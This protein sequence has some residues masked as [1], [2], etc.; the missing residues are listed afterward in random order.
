[1]SQLIPYMSPLRF[2]TYEDSINYLE[3]PPNIDKMMP[4]IEYQRGVYPGTYYPGFNIN[5]TISIEIH[6]DQEILSAELLNLDTSVSQPMTITDITPAV[7]DGEK[8]QLIEIAASEG[9]YKINVD[10]FSTGNIFS[11]EFLVKDWSKT[12]DL[13]EVE[14][15]DTLNRN[16]GYF[17]DETT[18]KWSP[19]V[20]Y[21]GN[22]LRAGTEFEKSEYSDQPN[23]TINLRITP[24]L[25]S[26]LTI[27][28]IHE[29]YY[30]NICHQFSCDTI[31]AN[32]T[33]YAVEEIGEP[34]P[35]EENTE[36]VNIIITLSRNTNNGFQ[37]FT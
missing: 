20:Y 16:G 30:D 31:I 8:I 15:R 7:W 37:Q 2:Y 3:F 25:K 36:L 9:Y 24:K 32:G 23:N 22:I 17:Y 29:S 33:Q 18:L 1:M 4:N 10:L 27:S 14:F 19:K 13:V 35:L 34:V 26:T 21:T 11:D 6:T 28:S 12:K 5:Q